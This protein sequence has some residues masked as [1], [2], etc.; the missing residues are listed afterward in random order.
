MS[1]PTEPPAWAQNAAKAVL[2]SL[3]GHSNQKADVRDVYARIIA[4]AAPKDDAR[5]LDW[6]ALVRPTIGWSPEPGCEFR[7]AARGEIIGN[8][9]TFRA[10]IDAA[11]KGAE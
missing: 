1:D 6:L 8:G 10:A 2:A 7:L 4:S 11:M 5:R 9:D 3:F